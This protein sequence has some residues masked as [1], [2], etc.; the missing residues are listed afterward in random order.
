[1]CEYLEIMLWYDDRTAL[2]NIATST[3][4]VWVG[5]AVTELDEIGLARPMEEQKTSVIMHF[6]G[7]QA[8]STWETVITSKK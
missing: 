6:S 5:I 8:F 2:R 1:M 4:A 3:A 7:H